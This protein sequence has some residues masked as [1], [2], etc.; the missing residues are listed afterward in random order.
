MPFI[1]EIDVDTG[2]P[3]QDYA[4]RR[5]AEYLKERQRQYRPEQI[6]RQRQQ[7]AFVYRFPDQPNPINVNSNFAVDPSDPRYYLKTPVIPGL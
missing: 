7:P 1:S 3:N 6:Q 5:F 2:Y 4:L